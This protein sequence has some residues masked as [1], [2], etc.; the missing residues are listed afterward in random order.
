MYSIKFPDMFTSVCTNL[1]KDKEATEQNLKLMLLSDRGSLFGDPYFGTLWRK[2][3][4]EQNNQILRDIIIDDILTSIQTFVPQLLV[5]RK[6]IEVNSNRSSI[7]INI[8]AVNI[9]DYETNLY[10]IKLMEDELEQ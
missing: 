8:K 6:D 5:Q 7:T 4:F 9:L 2:L 3:I 10:V 1:V